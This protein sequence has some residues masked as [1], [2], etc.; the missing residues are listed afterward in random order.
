M[1]TITLSSRGQI[2][3]PAAFRKK[4]GLAAGDQLRVDINEETQQITIARAETIDEMSA[5]FNS[6]IK[7]GTPPLLNTREVFEKRE[8][9]L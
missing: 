4:L 9:R 3:L 8:P 5:R 2:V 6:W 7:P 1:T